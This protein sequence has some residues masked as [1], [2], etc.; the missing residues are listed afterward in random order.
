MLLICP[1][2]N[3]SPWQ[4][5]IKHRPSFVVMLCKGKTSSEVLSFSELPVFKHR[6]ELRLILILILESYLLNIFRASPLPASFHWMAGTAGKSHN[7]LHS[8]CF[9]WIGECIFT[10]FK[11]AQ[12]GRDET[13]GNH[14][15]NRW[16]WV[17]IDVHVH[18]IPR[19]HGSCMP[20][21]TNGY[22]HLWSL[23]KIVDFKNKVAFEIG[24]GFVF[25]ISLVQFWPWRI[26][27]LS[28]QNS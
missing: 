10:S 8:H 26:S 16:F 2:S 9:F 15:A 11:C 22:V 20:L 25:F 18:F 19:M 7:I 4:M 12:K 14:V 21:F 23:L 28:I 5:Q 13:H 1:R 27:T 17:A 24:L 6:L 3:L